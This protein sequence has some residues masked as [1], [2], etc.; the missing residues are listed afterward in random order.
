MRTVMRGNYVPLAGKRLEEWRRLDLENLAPLI[1][2]PER[3]A[4]I[5]E[6]YPL[7]EMGQP[8]IIVDSSD[9]S[10][11]GK[12]KVILDVDGDTEGRSENRQEPVEDDSDDLVTMAAD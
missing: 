10:S 7:S 8:G 2:S 5:Q 1:V 4:W 6:R 3:S 12:R 9:S 11:Q